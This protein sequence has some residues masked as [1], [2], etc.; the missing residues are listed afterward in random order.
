MKRYFV[1]MDKRPNSKFDWPSTEDM[2]IHIDSRLDVDS[3]VY[4]SIEHFDLDRKSGHGAFVPPETDGSIR[5]RVLEGFARQAYRRYK[6]Q[7]IRPNEVEFLAGVDNETV[8]LPGKFRVV[9][10]QASDIVRWVYDNLD[11]LWDLELVE[12][13]PELTAVLQRH[14]FKDHWDSGQPN[15]YMYAPSLTTDVNGQVVVSVYGLKDGTGRRITPAEVL[16]GV[17][18]DPGGR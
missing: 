15:Y 13:S 12:P 10:T 5:R 17:V 7:V 14:T 16:A 2:A 18:D 9:N 1:V 3:T 8:A 11:P 6:G 4:D